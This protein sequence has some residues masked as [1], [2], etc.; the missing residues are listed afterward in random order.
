[1]EQAVNTFQKGL[2]SDVNPMIQG[3]DSLS[4]TLNATY[5]TMNGN[6]VVLQN[7]MGNRRIDN[8]YLPAGYQPVGMKEYGGVI[9]VASYNPITNKSQVGSFPSP[10]R[11]RSSF[12]DIN[13]GYKGFDFDFHHKDNLIS[14]NTWYWL[15]DDIKLYPLTR[16]YNGEKLHQ[17]ESEKEI[18]LHAGDKFSIYCKGINSYEN[19]ISNF[20]NISDEKVKSPK[21]RKYTLS[22]GILN[23]QNEFVDIT[24]TLKRWDKE[25]KIIKEE[26]F[27][28]DLYRFNDGYF[29]ASNFTSPDYSKTKNDREFIQERNASPLNTYSYKLVG[30]MYLKSELNHITDFD[31]NIYGS[32]DGNDNYTLTIEALVTYNCPDGC[33][34]KT[35]QET[36]DYKY[37][38]LSLLDNDISKFFR[39]FDFFYKNGD[40]WFKSTN[41]SQLKLTNTKYSNHNYNEVN[42]TYT[43]KVTKEYKLT[44]TESMLEYYICV[45]AF[46]SNIQGNLE[47]P[48]T[49]SYIDQE[50]IYIQGLS[51]SGTIDLNLLGS[52]LIEII[53]WRFYNKNGIT[54]LTYKL[55]N[56]PKYG[57]EYL[58]GKLL[59]ID[60]EN[61]IDGDKFINYLQRSDSRYVWIDNIP[62]G[63]GTHSLTFSW[64]EYGLQPNKMYIAYIWYYK[65]TFVKN[66]HTVLGLSERIN[67]DTP[68]YNEWVPANQN[69]ENNQVRW[70]L[71]TSLFNNCY[72]IQNSDFIVDYGNRTTKEEQETFNRL[73]TIGANIKVDVKDNCSDGGYVQEG[74]WLTK[75]W[76]QITVEYKHTYNIDYEINGKASLNKDIYPDYITINEAADIKIANPT[77]N[78]LNP[79]ID[80]SGKG[81]ISYE[82]NPLSE[83]LL[84]IFSGNHVKGTITYY[85]GLKSNTS[86]EGTIENGFISS[87][88]LSE[89]MNE[90]ETKTNSI[91]KYGGIFLGWRNQGSGDPDAR[92][93]DIVGTRKKNIENYQNKYWQI[94]ETSRLENAGGWTNYEEN[95]DWIQLNELN[96]LIGDHVG[97]KTSDKA[98]D[99]FKFFSWRKKILEGFNKFFN[100]QFYFYGFFGRGGTDEDRK[101]K[102]G[103]SG[104][105]SNPKKLSGVTNSRSCLNYSNL[106]WKTSDDSW[107]LIEGLLPLNTNNPPAPDYIKNIFTRTFI[108]PYYKNI[109]LSEITPE[110]YK[111][112]SDN[113]RFNNPYNITYI[114]NYGITVPSNFVK[115]GNTNDKKAEL[116]ND[117]NANMD[118]VKFGH[119]V[120]INSSTSTSENYSETKTINSGY[121]FADKAGNIINGNI[122]RNILVETGESVENGNKVY[123]YSKEGGI[124][125][126]KD[127]PY[128]LYSFD[129]KYNFITIN[130]DKIENKAPETYKL[131]FTGKGEHC[132]PFWYVDV[133]MISKNNFN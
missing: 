121:D 69:T 120:F 115:I 17:I 112:S 61:F 131:Q 87:E 42:N 51:D 96:E 92:F 43:I 85:D 122:I 107:V 100:N 29:I 123:R 52:G 72:D 5:M 117:I 14:C 11:K 82:I 28:S 49:G 10:E 71:T 83:E 48:I 79:I 53:G 20:N 66:W 74:N 67:P 84:G 62:L 110:L 65:N 63:L 102:F 128:S 41:T 22:V 37:L 57:E 24:K 3:T 55:K 6:E 36:D 101:Q 90:M 1:M 7:D 54:K 18:R 132:F 130:K 106:W 8:A 56:Y 9:Y 16:N 73:R 94:V 91:F 105:G 13:L 12:D 125:N 75:N 34:D 81:D 97:S 124:A 119:P 127:C 129:N 104:E 98:D 23:S 39:G 76:G 15:K 19:I 44:T 2:Q 88:R 58:N 109:E 25:A 47:P 60:L 40:N 111:P 78:V 21:N 33:P 116:L 68:K 70:L 103:D 80:Y 108:F 93:L 31:Y 118:D 86:Q 27:K 59:L 46:T 133:P 77:I 113:Y 35:K 89:I 38:N 30:P 26:E 114:L 50:N 45:P 32:N 126:W 99:K 64:E 95:K 4:D